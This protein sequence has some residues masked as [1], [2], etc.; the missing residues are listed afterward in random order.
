MPATG[1]RVGFMQP[2][3]CVPS[4]FD[5]RQDKDQATF[6]KIGK[7]LSQQG[8]G[9]KQLEVCLGFFWF[10]FPFVLSVCVCVLY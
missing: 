2:G 3:V 10:P 6:N 4:L 9:A 1:F 7:L 8:E 5:M